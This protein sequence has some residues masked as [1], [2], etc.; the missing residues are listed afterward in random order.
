MK[1][2]CILL[3]L[4]CSA[5]AFAQEPGG[6]AAQQTVTKQVVFPLFTLFPA[7]ATQAN[8][9]HVGNPGRAQ[10]CYWMVTNYQ[11]GQSSVQPAG[12]ANCYPTAPDI[13]SGTRYV[14]VT[15]V[16][17]VGIA[18]IDLLKTST[19]TP[20]SGACNCA[21]AT[22]VTSGTINDQSNSTLS[23]TISPVVVGNFAL[24][25]TNEVTG[26]GASSLLLRNYQ[27]GALICN[28][29]TGCGSSGAVTGS[30]TGTFLPIWTG[31]GASTALGNSGISETGGILTITD[32]TLTFNES[33]AN[34]LIQNGTGTC[35]AF[36]RDIDVTLQNINT[37]G[38]GGASINL[39]AAA[40]NLTLGGGALFHVGGQLTGGQGGYLELMP[41][42]PNSATGC[43]TACGYIQF[44]GQDGGIYTPGI[45]VIYG[46][47]GNVSTFERP[48]GGASYITCL[49]ASAPTGTGLVPVVTSTSGTIYN[50]SPGGVNC[51]QLSWQSPGG[52][53]TTPLVEG[54]AIVA[55]STTVAASSPNILD[56]T[57]G[58]GNGVTVSAPFTIGTSTSGSAFQWLTSAV[59]TTSLA[60][61]EVAGS[62]LGFGFDT[63]ANDPTNSPWWVNA[64]GKYRLATGGINPQTGNYTAALADQGK[65]IVMNCSA[66]CALTLPATPPNN[67]WDIQVETI[68]S[69]VATVSLNSLHFNGGTVGP[70]LQ[71]YSPVSITTDGSNYFGGT[72]LIE[73]TGIT[74]TPAAGGF[75]VALTSTNTTVNGSSCAL[76]G[77]CTLG[78]VNPQTAT[79]QV[80]AADF[81]ACKTIT[82]AS[83]TFTITLVAVGSQ[84]ANGQCINVFNYGSGVITIARSGQNINGQTS[85]IVLN[86]GSALAPTSANIVSDG[87]NY[88]ATVDEGTVGTVTNASALISTDVMTGAG[89]NAA[90]TPGGFTFSAGI[91]TVGTTGTTGQLCLAGTTAG[92]TACITTL[93]GGL[94][95]VFPTGTTTNPGQNYVS[96][97]SNSGWIG[98]GAG[99]VEWISSGSASALIGA[100]GY[101][102]V[103]GDAY[104]FNRAGSRELGLDDESA[105]TG[106]VVLGVGGSSNGNEAGFIRSANPC[107]PTSAVTLSGTTAVI[108]SWTLPAV[109]KTWRWQCQG[110]YAIT[111]GTTPGLTLQMNTAAGASTESGVAK[112]DTTTSTWTSSANTS[113]STG[114]QTITAG[115]SVGTTIANGEW[116]TSGFTT[117]TSSATTFAIQG[118]LS[119]TGSPA[120][121]ILVGSTCLL[122]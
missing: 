84:P 27:T 76:G 38:T 66:S 81:T 115:G 103:N 31:S 78:G 86:A 36:N 56:N 104:A 49:P 8:I 54:E 53:I 97:N 120:G 109:A 85:S 37:S 22:G 33:S 93:A 1:K 24:A 48:V 61:S 105:S 25:L 60:L 41:G 87:T 108:C 58:G 89:G 44:G 35:C 101:A 62:V 9:A 15:P 17:P 43:G 14:T 47:D 92:V 117:V 67:E 19:P 42:N 122:Y 71:S 99:G 57:V 2:V 102:T 82:V 121:T 114:A 75:T 77:S 11:L 119:G 21:V 95:L 113:A 100:A 40:T 112:I 51:Y 39:Q 69:S 96:N 30:G 98:N 94:T 28:L 64:S 70:V 3:F 20:P 45:L 18:S 106:G 73:G 72:A 23:Y 91:A 12:S 4:V 13:L 110:Q 79:Y 80:L 65:L 7:P 90:Q 6:N 74:F 107:A 50:G 68:G 55:Q 111:A 59:P 83:G 88:L 34:I 52:Q 5:L 63:T 118:I 32:N 10:I 29:S 26:T 46:D 16:Y 116:I